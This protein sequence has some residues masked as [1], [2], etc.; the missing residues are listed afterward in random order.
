M[1]QPV[2]A[3]WYVGRLPAAADRRLA[4]VGARAASTAE[5]PARTRSRGF[6]RAG[7]IRDCIGR[8]ARDRRGRAPG[9]ARR[10]RHD[11]RRARLRRRRHL[12]RSPRR[13]VRRRRRAR[14]ASSPSTRPARRRAADSFPRA[15]G[16]SPRW[17]RRCWWSRR[18]SRPARSSP[19]ASRCRLGRRVLAVPGSPGTD[20]LIATGAARRGR[21]TPKRLRAPW[22]VRHRRSARCRRASRRCWPRCGRGEWRAG[23]AGAPPG[24]CRSARRLALIAEAEL[25][26]WLCRRPGGALASMENDAWQLR[27]R[28]RPS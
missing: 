7:W 25:D 21:A 23:R 27:R 24:T 8:R 2:E 5:V 10:G 9:R 4:V 6:G 15:T 28:R 20:E 14:A 13:A 19:R 26:G 22:R 18:A 11:V 16:S 12:S 3:L 1:A 17:P